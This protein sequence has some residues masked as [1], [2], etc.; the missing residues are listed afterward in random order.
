MNNIRQSATG[1]IAQNLE[2]VAAMG[3]YEAINMIQALDRFGRIP[4]VGYPKLQADLPHLRVTLD[5]DSLAAV[6]SEDALARDWLVAIGKGINVGEPKPCID[7]LL[8][9]AR[10]SL[11][12]EWFAK[13][14]VA[15]YDTNT[16]LGPLKRLHD[17]SLKTNWEQMRQPEEPTALIIDVDVHRALGRHLF[18]T[19]NQSQLN[20]GF[21][22]RA[23]RNDFVLS[24]TEARRYISLFLKAHSKY[25]ARTNHTLNRSIYYWQ[26]LWHL[27]PA[28][29]EAWPYAVFGE[30]GLPGGDQI[31]AHM[32]SLYARLIGQM[33]ACDRIGWLRYSVPTS[34]GRDEMLNELNYFFMLATGIFDSLA[35]IALHRFALQAGRLD[36]TLREERPIGR[37]NPFFA[38]LDAVAP[39]FASF[40]CTRQQQA[41]ITLFYAPRDTIQHRLVLTGAHFNSGQIIS[42]CNIAY[43]NRDDAQAIQAPMTLEP[44]ATPLLRRADHPGVSALP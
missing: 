31:A 6:Q 41:K 44:A 16:M 39:A 11:G 40:L 26:R 14:S 19:C 21:I 28:F 38:S 24:P 29:Q 25:H 43:L 20:L 17:L 36:V 27:V 13:L 30:K 23:E 34:D 10:S 22:P 2:E 18:V 7:L 37:A 9:P 35:W 15:T 1:Q 3:V 12:A 4:Q 32:Q 42:D 8:T 33:Q 5:T